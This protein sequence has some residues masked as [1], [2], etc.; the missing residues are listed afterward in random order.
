MNGFVQVIRKANT[1]KQLVMFPF[2]GG[3]GYSYMELVNE[4]PRDT[5]IILIN[6]PGH[7][8]N[9]GPP[10]ESIDEMVYS[11]SKELRP[12][13]REGTLFFG[14]SIGGIVAYEICK[15]LEKNHHIK[16]MIIS[17]VTPPHRTM[18]DVDLHW[19]MDTELLVEKCTTLGGMPQLFREAP[20]LLEGFIMGLRADLKALEKYCDGNN[21]KNNGKINTGASIL[22][23]DGDYIVEPA[24]LKEWELY[25]DCSE[26]I[27]FSGDHFYLFEESNRKAVA[28]I[29][30]KNLNMPRRGPLYTE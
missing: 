29:L 12:L 18:D 16:K 5:E 25:L 8:L 7:L 19:E 3:S 10:L 6:P 17:S 26:Y 1:S 14:H 11:Y 4:I 28:R 20:E 9:G 24:K 30:T 15:G 13:L 27:K 2:G 21:I 23:S 22:Y